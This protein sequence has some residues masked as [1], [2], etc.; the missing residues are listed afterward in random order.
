MKRFQHGR[1]TLD[2]DQSLEIVAQYAER[3]LGSR[4]AQSPDQEPRGAHE[5]FYGAEG[6][7]GDFPAM[8]HPDRIGHGALVHVLKVI[9]IKTA[10]HL[11]PLRFRALRP[12][13]AFWARLRPI[14][15][16][17]L[18]MGGLVQ[19]QGLA[20]RAAPGV[21]LSIVSELIA[22]EVLLSLRVD[23]LGTWH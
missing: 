15:L 12:Q 7:L 14:F 13:R 9:L 5:P 17:L 21:A 3:Q 20:C 1:C 8:L 11:P 19:R 18:G 16:L 4:F 10:N 2:G 6:V 23:G 22:A